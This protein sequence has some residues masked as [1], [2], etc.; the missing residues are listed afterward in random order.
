MKESNCD[1]LVELPRQKYIAAYFAAAQAPIFFQNEVYLGL[2]RVV[3]WAFDCQITYL[4]GERNISSAVMFEF[5]KSST[6]KNYAHL[7]VSW[8]ISLRSV[9]SKW[10]PLPSTKAKP[11]NIKHHMMLLSYFYGG[12]LQETNSL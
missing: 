9:A 7:L 6:L 1:T 4:Y 3:D 8:T 5:E 11:V 12:V 10:V 2:C